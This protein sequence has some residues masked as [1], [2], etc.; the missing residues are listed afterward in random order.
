MNIKIIGL[1][2]I[3]SI[4]SEQI[5][6]FINYSK[7]LQDVAEITL[8]DGDVY[9][10]KNFER[11]DFSSVGKKAFIKE[12]DLKKKFNNIYIR[13]ITKFVDNY[14]TER[15]ISVSNIIYDKDVILLGVDNH[16]TR[17]IIS[18]FCRTL[19]NVTLI[20]GGN[21]FT[22]GNVQI[23]IRREGRD[24]TPDLCNY[25]PE[26]NNPED[27]HP[28]DMSCEELSH[29]EPQLLFT[30]LSVVSIMC[31]A[32]YN[33][34]ILNNYKYSEIYFDMIEMKTDSK[35]RQPKKTN[36]GIY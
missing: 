16:Q 25:H 33:Y 9:E 15:T 2:G 18:D 3:G 31:W 20:S 6:R 14:D 23:Y 27:K 22:D 21:D 36:E 19:N 5:T 12:R 11:Q 17:K 35:I 29:S 24:I 32:F 1:G 13:S 7:D 10:E 28:N 4:L 34:I 30:N 8:I 26:I